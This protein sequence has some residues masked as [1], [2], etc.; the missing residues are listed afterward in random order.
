MDTVMWR[1][2]R[3]GTTVKG[4]DSDGWS[5]YGVVLWLERRHNWVVRRVT[6]V[7]MIFL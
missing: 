5:S 4:N 7:E 1:D 2:D 6:K 3:R